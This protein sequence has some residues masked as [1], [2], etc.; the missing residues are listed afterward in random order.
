MGAGL[1]E[2]IA[3]DAPRKTRRA[4]LPRAST[5]HSGD[6]SKAP[7]N[8]TPR[9]L[10][11]LKTRPYIPLQGRSNAGESQIQRGAWVPHGVRTAEVSWS[12][13]PGSLRKEASNG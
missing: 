13:V 8:K 1:L 9:A 12:S 6:R 3:H 2:H 11:G 4:R 7:E 5:W 10:A